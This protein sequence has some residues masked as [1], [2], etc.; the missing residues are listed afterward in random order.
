MDIEY[1]LSK[2]LL[3]LYE[4]H[5]ICDELVQRAL[6][7]LDARGLIDEEAG[8]LQLPVGKPIFV[9]SSRIIHQGAMRRFVSLITHEDDG[10]PIIFVC[11]EEEAREVLGDDWKPVSHVQLDAKVEKRLLEASHFEDN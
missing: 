2:T 6:N 3:P 4:Y 7:S 11:T 1:N 8:T 9:F 5:E 10:K